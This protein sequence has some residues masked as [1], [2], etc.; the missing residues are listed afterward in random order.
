MSAKSVWILL[1]IIVAAWLRGLSFVRFPSEATAKR[2]V[3]SR[4]ETRTQFNARDK[5][6]DQ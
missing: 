4:A 6:F 3:E 1:C 2:S 5:G